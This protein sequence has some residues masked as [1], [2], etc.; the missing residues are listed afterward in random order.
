MLCIR[1][2]VG[3]IS[4]RLLT[5]I[6]AEHATVT[7]ILEISGGNGHLP[8][9][10]FM[11]PNG[12]HTSANHKSL[13]KFNISG[14][15]FLVSTS[16]LGKHPDCLLSSSKWL[17]GFWR[18]DLEAFYFDRDPVLFNS[19]LN[20]F[21]YDALSVPNG[22][23]N[24]MVLAEICFWKIPIET[25]MLD[26]DMEEEFLWMEGRIPPHCVSENGCQ[27]RN[28]QFWCFL[29]DPLGPYTEY[30]RLSLTY[31]ILTMISTVVYVIIIGMGTSM[32]YRVPV[33]DSDKNITMQ[34][35]QNES[36]YLDCQTKLECFT[37][38]E[39]TLSLSIVAFIFSC[40]LVI[41][42]LLRLCFCPD[43]R[44]YFRSVFSWIDLFSTICILLSIPIVLSLSMFLSTFM[45]GYLTLILQA[46]Q[47]LRLLKIFQVH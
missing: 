1:V 25:A 26:K 2:C 34:W 43:K 35:E 28:Y 44:I 46:F 17:E 23:N 24:N 7:Q 29:T 30:R 39:P 47:V 4:F 13:L 8:I 42:T 32:Y 9:R 12:E 14:Q 33:V 31:T 37:M 20:L 38:S 45:S 16:V 19:V 36:W 41:E 40:V 18:D 22:Y 6:M 10:D 21:R 27:R 15:E 11:P 5:P 3:L